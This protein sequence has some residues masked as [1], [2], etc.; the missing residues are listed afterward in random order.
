MGH[1][2]GTGLLSDQEEKL[3]VERLTRPD[4]LRRFGIGTLSAENPAYNPTGYHTG[5]VWVHDTAI[6]L[7]G[8]AQGGYSREADQVFDALV[9]LSA[10][11][12]HRF[13]ELIAG[14]PVGQDPVPYPAACRPQAWSAASAAVLLQHTQRHH[15]RQDLGG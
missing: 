3:V 8:M 4:M 6:I 1:A 7:R 15:T 11:S 12:Q 13:P 9:R 2:L 10:R 5:S 14:D